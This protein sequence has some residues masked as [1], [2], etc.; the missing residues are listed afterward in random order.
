MKK[1]RVCTVKGIPLIKFQSADRIKSLREGKLY[2]NTLEYYRNLEQD[3][4]D[5]D[6]G[7]TFEA[8]LHINEGYLFIPEN[9]QVSVL[10][11][12]LF[13]TSESDDLVFCMFS[14]EADIEHFQFS[15]EQKECYHLEI[16][17]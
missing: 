5:A 3:T 15:E 1:Q 17:R 11:D 14:V 6:I 7:D 10:N 16:Q 13:K 4:G 2:A 9:E 12:T 8:M